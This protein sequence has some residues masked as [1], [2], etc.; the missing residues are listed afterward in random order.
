MLVSSLELSQAQASSEYSIQANLQA[1]LK[2]GLHVLHEVSVASAFVY[3]I[4]LNMLYI[5]GSFDNR[6]A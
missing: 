6:M 5:L 2:F 1:G 3:L 4:L